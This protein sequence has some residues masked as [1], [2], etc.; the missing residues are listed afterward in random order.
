MTLSREVEAAA[1]RFGNQ[2][3]DRLADLPRDR[4]LCLTVTALNGTQV[5]VSWRGSTYTARVLAAYTPAVNDRALCVL[6][7][8]N[9]LIAI[10]RIV[11]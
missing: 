5:D 2:Q 4:H 7:T 3:T 11:P 8:D 6:T 10:G 9:Q 1:R